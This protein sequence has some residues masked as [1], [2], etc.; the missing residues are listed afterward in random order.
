MG[1]AT[2]SEA[3]EQPDTPRGYVVVQSVGGTY[4][5]KPLNAHPIMNYQEAHNF[6]IGWLAHPE[7]TADPLAIV[8]FKHDTS[9]FDSRIVEIVDPADPKDRAEIDWYR[10]THPDEPAMN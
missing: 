1:E 9:D 3:E 8:E 10:R 4:D 2:S 7:A 6:A 5:P